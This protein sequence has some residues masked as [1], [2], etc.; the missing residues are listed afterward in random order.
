MICQT[1]FQNLAQLTKITNQKSRKA[2]EGNILLTYSSTPS[3]T[4]SS[5]IRACPLDKAS[6][7]VRQTSVSRQHNS[8]TKYVPLQRAT[9]QI[10]LH[11]IHVKQKK[12]P[13]ILQSGRW[14]QHVEYDDIWVYT[15][16]T[17]FSVENVENLFEIYSGFKMLPKYNEA[18]AA[19]ASVGGHFTWATQ[20]RLQKRNSEC[21]VVIRAWECLPT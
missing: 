18:V 14:S 21:V 19:V 12:L 5:A 20:L 3:D 7:V 6:K 15:A 13:G 9:G 10:H 8:H 2:N 4:R 11:S 1:I 17:L 16:L